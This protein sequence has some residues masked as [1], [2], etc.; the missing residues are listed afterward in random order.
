MLTIRVVKSF[1]YND[2][3]SGMEVD[4]PAGT[5]EVISEKSFYVSRKWGYMKFRFL[6][7]RNGQSGC[8]GPGAWDALL[9]EGFIEVAG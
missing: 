8:I 3:L 5:I 1:L 6:K 2:L 9:R 7:R 4:V